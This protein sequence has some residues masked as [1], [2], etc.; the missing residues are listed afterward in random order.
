MCITLLISTIFVDKL[1]A[2]SSVSIYD[3]VNMVYTEV[4][5]KNDQYR[6]S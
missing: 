3:V 2:I 1:V 5:L 4:W 6:R